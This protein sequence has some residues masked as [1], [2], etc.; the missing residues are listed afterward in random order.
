MS[1]A[2]LPSSVPFT[3]LYASSMTW[4]SGEIQ[5]SEPF[6][7]VMLPSLS[8]NIPFGSSNAFRQY[9]STSCEIFCVPLPVAVT[10]SVAFVAASS[11]AE[12]TIRLS[13]SRTSALQPSG[14][15][16]MLIEIAF[17]AAYVISTVL[18][19]TTN[20]GDS[21][22]ASDS[23]PLPVESSNFSEGASSFSLLQLPVVR[24]AANSS[25]LQMDLVL[26]KKVVII[27][28]FYC[29]MVLLSIRTPVRCRSTTPM[30]SVEHSPSHPFSWFTPVW[31][32][33]K[34]TPERFAG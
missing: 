20:T 18:P 22:P 32:R 2:T 21:V 9:S 16:S 33:M 24:A 12:R 17:S 5:V 13:A 15:A 11:V 25:R 30:I 10:V 8:T 34:S 3:V 14:S 28:E 26:M 23:V 19:G 6:S 31:M 29:L 1:W 7:V 4:P 27:R